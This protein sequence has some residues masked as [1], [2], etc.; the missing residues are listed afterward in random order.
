MSLDEELFLWIN[1]AASG[2]VSTAVM[3][4]ITWLG[5]GVVLALLILPT[6]YLRRRALFR[7][8]ALA[9]II[10]VALSGLIV[11]GLKIV[12]D[13]PRPPEHFGDDASGIVVHTPGGVPQDRSFPSGHTQTAFGTAVYL[14]CLFPKAAPAFLLLAALVGLSRVTLGVHF[15]SDVIVGGAF[16]AAFSLVAFLM[17]RGKEKGG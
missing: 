11:N 17:V 3:S 15:P 13:R 12:V 9:M 2:P 5:N 16:G 10:A 14:S 8:H 6:F 4:A 7:R 1:Q